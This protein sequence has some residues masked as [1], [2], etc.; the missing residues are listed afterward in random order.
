MDSCRIKNNL[1]ISKYYNGDHDSRK[2]PHFLKPKFHQTT[3]TPDKL[4]FNP[5]EVEIITCP[6]GTFLIIS[7]IWVVQSTWFGRHGSVHVVWS[8]WFGLSKKT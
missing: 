5:D 7:L 3:F 6:V 1:V 4:I 2:I 8:M